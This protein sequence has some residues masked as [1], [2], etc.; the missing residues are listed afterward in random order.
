MNI[1]IVDDDKLIRMFF[2]S[3]LSKKLACTIVEAGNGLDALLYLENNPVELILL[4]ISM[5]I[6]DGLELLKIIR[7]TPAI[8]SIPVIVMSS[9]D[10]KNIVIKLIQLGISDYILKP[11]KNRLLIFERVLKA[12]PISTGKIEERKVYTPSTGI[13][14]LLIIDK[15]PNFRTYFSATLNDKFLIA[16]TG[17]AAEGIKKYLEILPDIVC[18]SEG[19]LMMDP[20]KV[21]YKIASFDKERRSRIY[22]CCEGTIPE[23]SPPESNPFNG[24]I[25]KSF[26]PDIFR[27]EFLHVVSGEISSLGTFMEVLTNQLPAELITS[28]RQT[29]GVMSMQEVSL[30]PEVENTKIAFDHIATVDLVNKTDKLL[31]KVGIAFPHKDIISLAKKIDD[32]DDVQSIVALL[33]TIAGR[34]C[35]SLSIRGY[36]FS[37]QFVKTNVDANEFV[38]NKFTLQYSFETESAER[39]VFGLLI[40][41]L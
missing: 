11:F 7:S 8:S 21:A 19:L 4:D 9:S 36:N 41:T 30:L 29:F 31:L 15:D 32:D 3:L 5:P 22:Y 39:F 24:S 16:E 12:L 28:I 27:Y 26:V 40:N 10:E 2:Q 20:E 1:L 14:K 6:M 37:Q 33:E 18:I 25:K 23:N 34:I 35:S 17:S 38:R 13:Q